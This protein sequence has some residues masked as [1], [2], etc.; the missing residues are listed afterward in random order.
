M[1]IDFLIA[2][3]NANGIKKNSEKKRNKQKPTN[4]NKTQANTHRNTM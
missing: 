2:N 3:G 4:N 1:R